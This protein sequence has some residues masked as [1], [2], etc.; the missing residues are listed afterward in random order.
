MKKLKKGKIIILIVL[1]TLIIF[2]LVAFRNSRAEKIIPIIATFT[3]TAEK[4]SVIKETIDAKSEA[5]SGYTVILP[6][7]V[8]NKKVTKYFVTQ[9]TINEKTGSNETL[10]NAEKVAMLPGDKIYLTD[11]E[12]E[13]KKLD[14]SIEYDKKDDLYNQKLIANSNKF[15]IEVEGYFP[16]DSNL[17]IETTDKE[18]LNND[19]DKFLY[20]TTFD[21][22]YKVLIQQNGKE[23]KPT[24]DI[25]IT[26]KSN[27]TET[28]IDNTYKIVKADSTGNN[29]IEITDF[30][31]EQNKI[32]FNTSNL[33]I[34]A[35]L[36]NIIIQSGANANSLAMSSM[37][38]RTVVTNSEV[39]EDVWDGRGGPYRVMRSIGSEQVIYTA[40]LSGVPTVR[41][42]RTVNLIYNK[43]NIKLTVTAQAQDDAG[44][45]D[46]ITVRNMQ[47]KKLVSATVQSAD[48]V[49]IN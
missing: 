40:D 25:K 12:L 30:T 1:L 10:E 26:F 42:G 24:E 41:R 16:L 6:D 9:K 2:E 15:N 33:G 14:L 3:D 49:L 47:S 17:I 34:F 28:L 20:T 4:V 36:K 21:V 8:N 39:M 19:I 31:I 43:G 29:L 23:F 45:G 27:E 22:A 32:Y 44:L 37:Q 18:T 13:L 38:G 35:I 5:E 11:E 7:M 46:V 48:T